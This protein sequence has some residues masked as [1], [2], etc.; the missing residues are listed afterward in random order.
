MGRDVLVVS[1]VAMYFLMTVLMSL[2]ES[3]NVVC[4]QFS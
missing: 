4:G 3:R 2:L 1:G